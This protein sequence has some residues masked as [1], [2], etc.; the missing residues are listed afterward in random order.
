MMHRRAASCGAIGSG[1][2]P[3][4]PWLN[5]QQ[6]IAGLTAGQEFHLPPKDLADPPR[7]VAIP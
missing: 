7:F 6:R 1:I 4:L 2:S 5:N 3:D